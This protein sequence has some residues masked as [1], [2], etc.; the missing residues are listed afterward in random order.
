MRILIAEDD[1]VSRQLLEAFLKKWDCEPVVC[2]GGPQAWEA[3]Q[4][5]AAPRMAILD[6]M[7]PELEG[8]EIVRLA[9]ERG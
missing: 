3:L 8:P 7:M 4:R 5:L 9:R 2:C 6:W 1:P